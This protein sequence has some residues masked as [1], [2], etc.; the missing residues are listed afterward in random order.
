MEVVQPFILAPV[1]SAD[2]GS[3]ER[4]GEQ[5][6]LGVHLMFAA[7]DDDKEMVRRSLR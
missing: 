7:A 1:L 6:E 5:K 2:V 3:S 4:D